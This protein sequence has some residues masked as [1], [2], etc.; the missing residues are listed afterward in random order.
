MSLPRGAE[1]GVIFAAIG[2]AYGVRLPGPSMQ[3]C[4]GYATAARLWPQPDSLVQGRAR[5]TGAAKVHAPDGRYAQS[6]E[7]VDMM[8]LGPHVRRVQLTNYERIARPAQYM[9]EIQAL[10]SDMCYKSALICYVGIDMR[11]TLRMSRHRRL[12]LCF[13]WLAMC[14]WGS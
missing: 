10:F 7:V 1:G 6:F 13:T 11:V 2:A 8:P 5:G 9:D 12:S 3:L 14:F 4:Q